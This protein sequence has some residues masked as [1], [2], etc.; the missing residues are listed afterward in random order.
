MIN[1]CIEIKNLL[2]RTAFVSII[3]IQKHKANS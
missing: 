3:S 2:D 1:S